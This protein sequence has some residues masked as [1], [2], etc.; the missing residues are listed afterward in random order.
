MP[1]CSLASLWDPEHPPSHLGAS[2]TVKGD[3]MLGPRGYL[4]HQIS[5]VPESPRAEKG[6]IGSKT[7]PATCLSEKGHEDRKV[8]TLGKPGLHYG[9]RKHFHFSRILVLRDNERRGWPTGWLRR[10]SPE[11]EL[12]SVSWAGPHP[13]DEPP[14]PALGLGRTRPAPGDP[15]GSEPVPG[16]CRKSGTLKTSFGRA[17][18]TIHDCAHFLDGVSEAQAE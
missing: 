2:C 15:P 5:W 6:G 17:P 3:A 8:L 12:H 9:P 16:C 1:P 13:P 7:A 14:P 11:I 10:P 4:P 18:V